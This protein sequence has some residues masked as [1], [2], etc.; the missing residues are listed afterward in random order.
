MA[1]IGAVQAL[2]PAL[3]LLAPAG[4]RGRLTVLI[5]HRVLPEPDSMLPGDVDAGTFRWHLDLVRRLFTPLPLAEAVER[6]QAGTLPPRA[7]CVSFDDGYADN[8]TVALPML[9][10]AGVPATFFIA[11]DYLDGG[12]M[13]NDRIIESVRRWPAGEHELGLD[14]IERVVL[15]TPVSRVDACNALIRKAKYLAPPEREALAHRLAERAA[16]SLPAD[17]MMSRAQVLELSQAGMEI[18]GHTAGHPILA[19][20]GDQEA[21]EEI[22]RGRTALEDMIGEPVCL[23]AYPNGKPGQDYDGRHVAMVR[24]LGFRAAMSTAWGAASRHSDPYQLPRFTPWD[25]TPLRFAA[26]LARNL[27]TG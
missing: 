15:D 11:T 12:M 19:R 7:L 26:R 10:E 5:Y 22:R 18:G 9:R 8:A 17:L 21:L 27:L 24:D 25:R 20:L 4:P 1:S 23:F 13:F 16:S 14:G 3:S 2:R 6:L